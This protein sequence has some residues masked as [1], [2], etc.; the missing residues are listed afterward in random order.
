MTAAQRT[1]FD[2]NRDGRIDTIDL[3]RF[4][5]EDVMDVVTEITE[6]MRR[7][8]TIEYE[9]NS[10]VIPTL[11]SVV[12]FQYFSSLFMLFTFVW[13]NTCAPLFL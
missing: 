9:K 1:I 11:L 7:P 4:L 8:F 6:V 10:L 2:I 13:V 5:E 3:L 12:I